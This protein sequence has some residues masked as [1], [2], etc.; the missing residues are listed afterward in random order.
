MRKHSFNEATFSTAIRA[1]LATSSHRNC[2]H[3]IST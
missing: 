2:V 1:W 3:D